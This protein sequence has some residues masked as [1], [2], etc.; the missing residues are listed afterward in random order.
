MADGEEKDIKMARFLAFVHIIVGFL[1]IG[2]GI[3]DR[4]LEY[5][6]TGHEYYGIWIGGWVSFALDITGLFEKRVD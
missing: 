2:L 4:V 3:T 5:Y 6:V 1:L